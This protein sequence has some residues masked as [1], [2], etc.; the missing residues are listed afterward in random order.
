MYLGRHFRSPDRRPEQDILSAY[1]DDG[2]GSIIKQTESY[3]DF[4]GVILT[5]S[6]LEYSRNQH[7]PFDDLRINLQAHH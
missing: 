1:Y 4:R 2:S 7:L 3:G 5:A 6:F